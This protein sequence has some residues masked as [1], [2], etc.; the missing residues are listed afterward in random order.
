MGRAPRS[1][2][3]LML[4]LPHTPQE[5]PIK[6]CRCNGARSISVASASSTF[7]IFCCW[8]SSELWLAQYRRLSKSL[9]RLIM[10]S[11]Y[12]KPATRSKSSPGVRIVTARLNGCGPSRISRGS[13]TTSV[14]TANLD[15]S[16]STSRIRTSLRPLR[17]V[18]AVIGICDIVNS[19]LPGEPLW[20]CTG[21]TWIGDRDG[22]PLLG[23][24]GFLGSGR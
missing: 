2:R 10:P 11:L 15:L 13:S 20:P 8:P 3:E 16:S 23:W 24:H 5:L 18:S 19:G 14:S 9:L 21:D 7:I 1:R 22:D 4:A 17:W 6:K 12:K